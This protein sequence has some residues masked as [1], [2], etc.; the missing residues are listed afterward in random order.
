MSCD[1]KLLNF[2]ARSQVHLIWPHKILKPWMVPVCH[3]VFEY[4][5]SLFEFEYWRNRYVI[6]TVNRRTLHIAYETLHEK[7]TIA[8]APKK[9][10][11]KNPGVKSMSHGDKTSLPKT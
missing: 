8:L 7:V 2:T 11:P 1:Y 10:P 6:A 9:L 5:L 4:R 3:F